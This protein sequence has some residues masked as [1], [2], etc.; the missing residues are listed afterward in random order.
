MPAGCPAHLVVVPLRG[1]RPPKVHGR[2]YPAVGLAV[3]VAE[4]VAVAEQ[5]PPE[6]QGYSKRVDDHH[7]DCIHAVA[8]VERRVAWC[9]GKGGGEVE[10][11]QARVYSIEHG[12]VPQKASI[13]IA[14][15]VYIETVP[16]KGP[17]FLR[18]KIAPCPPV[19]DGDQWV[20]RK[21]KKPIVGGKKKK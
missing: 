2:P 10:N 11:P 17:A 8:V 19:G 6:G 7:Q 21:T 13:G 15:L 5:P 16:C 12:S 4:L 9:A 1:V 3:R 20:G 18:S 14:Q